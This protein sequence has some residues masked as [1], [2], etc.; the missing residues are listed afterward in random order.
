MLVSTAIIII[1]EYHQVKVNNVYIHRN[2][3]FLL[4]SESVLHYSFPAIRAL[5]ILFHI[6]ARQKMLPVAA[7]D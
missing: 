2:F 6:I 3:V 1:T 4:Q 7:Y 5:Q